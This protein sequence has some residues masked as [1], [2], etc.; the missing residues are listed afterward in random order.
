MNETTRI[1]HSYER[2]VLGALAPLTEAEHIARYAFAG[3]IVKGMAVGDIACGSG[4]GCKMLLEHGAASVVGVDL[5]D[6]AIEMAK[7][8]CT[9]LNANFWRCNAESLSPIESASLDAVV[10]FET[11]EHVQSPKLFLSEVHRI[12]RP[13]GLFIVSTPD[14]RLS[15]PFYF[16]RKKP[17]NKYHVHEYSMSEFSQII[18]QR[19]VIEEMRGQSIIPVILASLPMQIAI[20]GTARLLRMSTITKW[21]DGLY[22]AQGDVTVTPFATRKGVAKYLVCIAKNSPIAEK[23]QRSARSQQKDA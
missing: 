19:F 3:N 21:K 11:I 10:S 6:A 2:M 23:Q 20:K 13:N 17:T 4:Y 18:K 22:S 15:S 14:R 8:K 12:L 7:E 9:G 1:A 5:S 16:V